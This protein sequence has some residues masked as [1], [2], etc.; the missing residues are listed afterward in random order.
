M[1]RLLHVLYLCKY[2]SYS[3]YIAYTLYQT[4][5]LDRTINS[6]TPGREA[7]DYKLGILNS[8]KGRYFEHISCECHKASRRII[9][10]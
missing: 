6:L 7:Y 5:R 1:F 10:H 4:D 8:W 3:R 2:Q 9:Q